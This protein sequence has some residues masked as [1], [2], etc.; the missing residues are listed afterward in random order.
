MLG[1]LNFSSWVCIWC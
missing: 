1:K